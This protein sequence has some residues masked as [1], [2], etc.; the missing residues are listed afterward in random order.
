MWGWGGFYGILLGAE[1][2]RICCY[3]DGEGNIWGWILLGWYI[4]A[5]LKNWCHC[6]SGPVYVIF[7][8]IRSN[9]WENGVL[10]SASIGL[11][12]FKILF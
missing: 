9:I 7:L 5:D 1:I 2:G 6:E 10:R 4:W 11:A 12:N 3:W 8:F